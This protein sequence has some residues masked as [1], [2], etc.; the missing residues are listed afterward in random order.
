MCLKICVITDNVTLKLLELVKLKT[1]I[2]RLNYFILSIKN[3]KSL[4]TE[5]SS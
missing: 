4:S 2:L 5:D 3:S 1:S